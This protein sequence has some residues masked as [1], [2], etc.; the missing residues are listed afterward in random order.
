MSDVGSWII[1]MGSTVCMLVVLRAALLG[2][3]CILTPPNAIHTSLISYTQREAFSGCCP[4]LFSSQGMIQCP[5]NI[6][7]YNIARF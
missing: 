4:N 5:I 1:N 6:A 2:L 7:S 3:C